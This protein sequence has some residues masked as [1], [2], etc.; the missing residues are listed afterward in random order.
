MGLWLKSQITNNVEMKATKQSLPWI[1]LTESEELNGNMYTKHITQIS[2]SLHFFL[3]SVTLANS[4]IYLYSLAE[5]L[6]RRK[7]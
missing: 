6:S 2:V 1:S 7:F 3:I 4:V 5:N